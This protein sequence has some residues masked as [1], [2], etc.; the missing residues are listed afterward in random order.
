LLE[1]V[2]RDLYFLASQATVVKSP[3]KI[4]PFDYASVSLVW[5]NLSFTITRGRGETNVS[6]APGYAPNELTEIGPTIAALEGRHLSER[7]AVNS[8]ADAAALLRPRLDLLNKAVAEE[9]NR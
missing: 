6:V 7:D 8:L 3:T 1:D 9:K 5:E 2:Q 4:L